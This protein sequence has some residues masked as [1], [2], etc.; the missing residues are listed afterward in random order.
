MEKS[1][2]NV[3]ETCFWGNNNNDTYMG[4]SGP[5][6][7]LQYNLDEYIPFIKKWI[8]TNNIKS[9]VDLGCGDFKCG[10]YIYDDLNVEYTGYDVYKKIIDYHNTNNTNEKYNFIHLDIFGDKENIKCAELCILK[11][12]LQHW[13]LQDIYR[14]LDYIIESKKFKYVLICNCCNQ[15]HDDV[16]LNTTGHW[17]QLS[18]DYLPLKKYKPKKLLKFKTKEISIIN[19]NEVICDK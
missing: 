8:D 16:K 6:S 11:D 2:T 4:S 3:Y 15:T 5:G 10:K 9:V 12:V 17:R 14:F 19:I 18:C 13:K 1:F 7:E